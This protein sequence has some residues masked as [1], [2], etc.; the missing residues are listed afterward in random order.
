MKRFAPVDSAVL[1]LCVAVSS[2]IASP[3]QQGTL[4]EPGP[5]SAVVTCT[6][7]A[8]T[9]DGVLDEPIWTAAPGIGELVQRQPL[10]GRPPTERTDVTVICDRDHLYVGVVS[11]DSEPRRIIGTQMA[12]D[13]S[14][15]SDDRVEIV[16]DTFRDQRSAFYF[17][18]NPSGA[19]VDGLVASGELNA[20][21]DAI[22]NVRT[23]RSERGWIAEFAI[24]F[25]SL[26]FPAGR[27]VW[28]FNLSRTVH[29]KLEE[30]RWSGARLDVQFTQ[31]SEAG[32]ITGLV[33]LTQGLG[34]DV[35]PFAAGRVLHTAG[36]NDT[37]GKPGLD[38]F[39]NI[40]PSLK[41]TATVNTDFGETEVDARQ[42]NLTRYSL[43]FPEKRSFFLQGAGVFGFASTGPEPA[44][45]IPSAGADVYPFF[46]R[47]IGL[48][49]GEEV[50]LEAGLKLTGTVGRTDVGVL[51][52]RTGDLPIVSEKNFFVGRVKRNLLQQSY[53][54]AIVT[55][56]DPAEGQTGQTY[57]ADVR[58][59]TSRFLGR[60]NN[61]VVNGYGVRSAN[62]GVSGRDWSYGF[63]AHYPN[64]RF[65]AQIAFREIQENF[66]PALGFVQR[67]NVRLL[68]VAG[69]YN[70]RPKSF[71]NVQQM[72]HDVYY[73][74]FTRL[75]TGLVESWD[76]YVTLLDWHLSSG[77]NLH[78]MF[79]FNPT[80]ERLFEPFEISPGVV[81]LPGEYRFTRFRSNL[82]STATKRRLSGSVNLTYGGYWSGKAEQ[83]TTSLTYKLPPWFTMT[84]GTNQT[85]ARLPEGHF[86]ARIFSASIGYSAT[87]SV[88]LSNLVQYDNRSR[89]L[90]WQ[91]RLRWTLQPGNDLFFAFNQ[92]WVQ[93]DDGDR[94]FRPQDSRISAKVQYSFRF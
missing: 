75:D 47:Q 11:H 10:Q 6:M 93:D 63:S 16:L 12:R 17:A 23:N 41:L 13:A 28:G 67:N 25:K 36:E 53:V 82:L 64:D 56:G 5:R 39:Y 37:S 18:T 80:Y 77:D 88:S 55:A 92:G 27:T 70:P 48:L 22:W 84:L 21:W 43:L 32:E 68:R 38:V 1:S 86:I 44:G 51:G 54:G 3:L 69:S 30:D 73:T 89:N 24:P 85:F 58:L 34:L 52:V 72:F 81:L 91:S 42:I 78:G 8:I 35:R 49:D 14:L 59:A 62:E 46:S 29:R 26:S 19:L 83:L 60:P 74:R 31:V 76:V 87:P 94:R 20:E 61:L 45:G 40:T 7:D 9:I 71:L 15:S 2:A 50:P 65:N 4:P 33:G 90:G 57:G 66:R 79:D